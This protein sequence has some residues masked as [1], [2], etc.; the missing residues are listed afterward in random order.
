MSTRV[1]AP[2]PAHRAQEPTRVCNGQQM[3]EHC[4]QDPRSCLG[5]EQEQQQ[6]CCK[7]RT[8]AAHPREATARSAPGPRQGLAQE[9][10]GLQVAEPWEALAPEPL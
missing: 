5:P 2:G 8:Q 4:C 7:T 10:V 1:I 6:S 9:A 3:L